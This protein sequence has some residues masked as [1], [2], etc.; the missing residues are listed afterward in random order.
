MLPSSSAIVFEEKSEILCFLPFAFC[1]QKKECKRDADLDFRT[2]LFPCLL[3]L[4]HVCSIFNC[5]FEVESLFLQCFCHTCFLLDSCS[6][7]C[8][9]IKQYKQ[10]LD[11]GISGFEW[12]SYLCMCVCVCV[13]E[14]EMVLWVFGY[15][16]LLW[17]AGFDY[18]ERV[19]GFIKG[20]RRV[21]HQGE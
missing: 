9:A 10:T 8:T 11:N 13:E 21:F 2:A 17:K 19:V 4:L 5:A 6:Y 18:E 15:G 7:F 16:S 3:H 20:Y 12:A 14:R 1:I